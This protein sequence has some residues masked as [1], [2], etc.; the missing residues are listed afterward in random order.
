M[1]AEYREEPESRQR[2]P[3]SSAPHRS[4]GGARIDGLTLGPVEFESPLERHALATLALCHDVLGIE[5]QPEG[6]YE[7]EGRVRVY[8]PDFGL[9]LAS[10]L[11]LL[12]E[13]KSLAHLV[14]ATALAR[15]LPIAR[16]FLARD[17]GFAFLTDA[18]IEAQPR[19]DSVRLLVRYLAGDLPGAVRARA[20]AALADGPRPISELL[21]GDDAV[22]LAAIY[23]LLARRALCFDWRAPLDA[24]TVVSLPDQ[25]F[26][27]LRL[28][29]ILHS[30]RFGPLLAELALGRRPEDQPRLAAAAAWRPPRRAPGPFGFVGG[31][32]GGVP[33]RD[34]DP[35]ERLPGTPWRRRARV[36]GGAAPPRGG[37]DR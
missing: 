20:L 37:G 34:L 31:P 6:I 17:R 9:R 1:N 11:R 28:A 23:T 7:A 14:R 4:T 27:G 21:R 35:A 15:Y 8:H 16:W 18:Q 25:P 32:G 3:V 5:S 22:D 30:T 24:R 36:P 26:E 29:D 10:G 33:L 12:L 19:F 2:H 13:V